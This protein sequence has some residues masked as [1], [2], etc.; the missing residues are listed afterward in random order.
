[1]T[2]VVSNDP[3]IRWE[4]TNG[5]VHIVGVRSAV[6]R[7]ECLVVGGHHGTD[8][9]KALGP[10]VTPDDYFIPG[11]TDAPATCFECIREVTREW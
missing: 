5:V 4:A 1:M 3:E 7:T 8:H 9:E 11:S 10:V 2:V 6:H